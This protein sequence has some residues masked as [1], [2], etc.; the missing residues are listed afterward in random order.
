MAREEGL[1]TGG[2]GGVGQGLQA[3]AQEQQGEG[4]N[5]GSGASSVESMASASGS[6][7][8]SPS[9]A[10][11]RTISPTVIITPRVRDILHRDDLGT[12]KSPARRLFVDMPGAKSAAASGEQVEGAVLHVE[13]G[14]RYVGIHCIV[15]GGLCV[16][17][18]ASCKVFE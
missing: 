2:A 5:A 4:V 13:S 16:Q 12:G 3:G 9:R 17:Q 14:T 7:S 1:R 6:A 11:A 10:I 18:G 8:T 15:V